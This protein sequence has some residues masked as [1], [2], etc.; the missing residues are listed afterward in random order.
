MKLANTKDILLLKGPHPLLQGSALRAKNEYKKSLKLSQTQRNIIVGTLLG[1]AHLETRGEVNPAVRYYFSQKE[2][3]EAY[4]RHI[5]SHFE[6]WCSK[7]PQF[8]NSGI[9]VNAE[10][11][12]LRSGCHPSYRS[13]TDRARVYFRTCT[14]PAF[15]FYAN[16]FYTQERASSKRLKVVPKLLHT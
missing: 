15:A 6:D 11:T 5:Y 10:V 14:H 9:N 4:V 3:Q 7:E 12:R 16:Q 13:M 1:D 2:S 8:A